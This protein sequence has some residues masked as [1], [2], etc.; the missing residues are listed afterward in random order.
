MYKKAKKSKI[1]TL[2]DFEIGR[3]KEPKGNIVVIYLVVEILNSRMGEDAIHLHIDLPRS[4][5]KNIFT[6]KFCEELFNR[7]PDTFDVYYGA[8]RRCKMKDID[9]LVELIEEISK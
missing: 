4:I 7:L 6:Q 1:L 3:S 2:Y 8:D 5:D 9:K